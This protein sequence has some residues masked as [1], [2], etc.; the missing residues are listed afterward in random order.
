[1]VPASL[2]AL[3]EGPEPINLP[4]GLS[5]GVMVAQGPLEAFVMV[6]IHVGQPLPEKISSG[7]LA[8]ACSKFGIMAN[9]V[10]SPDFIHWHCGW[11]CLN[12]AEV[13]FWV[14]SV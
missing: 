10:K 1:M 5:D 6:R 4:V 8:I 3:R 2:L 13:D 11:A 12:T 9:Q 14:D 7:Q